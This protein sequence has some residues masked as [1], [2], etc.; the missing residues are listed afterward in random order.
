MHDVFVVGDGDDIECHLLEEL[1]SSEMATE[2]KTVYIVRVVGHPGHGARTTDK[3]YAEAA[4]AALKKQ[5][6]NVK[7]V[8]KKR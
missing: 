4:M 1:R 6:E 8:E 7:I 2:K 5:Y 3:A